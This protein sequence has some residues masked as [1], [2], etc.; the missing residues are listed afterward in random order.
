MAI[1][2]DFAPRIRGFVVECDDY[3]T[4]VLN[5]RHS[6]AMNQQTY[7]HEREHIDNE[8]S[9]SDMPA[10]EIESIRHK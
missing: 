8:D 4:I 3:S 9:R 1:F 6:H 2:H 5:S 7:L 10:D